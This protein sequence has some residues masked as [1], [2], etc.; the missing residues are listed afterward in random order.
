MGLAL[1]THLLP[2]SLTGWMSAAGL[3]S[4]SLPTSG[5]DPL[6]HLCPSPY[7]HSGLSQG[8]HHPV[9]TPSD[10]AKVPLHLLS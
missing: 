7:A 2:L 5:P 6:S 4:T 3:A 9:L 10:R 8:P 1:N